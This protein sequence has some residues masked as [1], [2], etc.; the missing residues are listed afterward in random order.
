MQGSMTTESRIVRVGCVVGA[1][2]VFT[3]ALPLAARAQPGP[4]LSGY[5]A[6]GQGNQVILG[7]TLLGGSGGGTSS[8]SGGQSRLA[9]AAS[10]GA[11]A[12]AA[13]HPRAG[14]A[15][16]TPSTRAGESRT[17]AR[18]AGATPSA[19]APASYP[20]VEPAAATSPALGLSGSD[21]L[22]VA[23]AAAALGLTGLMT[24]RMVR[25]GPG[26]ETR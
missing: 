1:W 13:A 3:A 19:S 23:L 26:R 6:P 20:A 15:G 14:T 18:H 8:G 7:S 17:G 2:L 9:A 10:A 4:L 21:V 24:R 22:Y 11:A 16:A 25:A 12:A 5:G